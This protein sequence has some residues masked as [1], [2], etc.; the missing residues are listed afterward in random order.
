[1]KIFVALAC[2]L[3]GCLAQRPHPCESPPLLTG[4]FSV[5]AQN[6]DLFGLGKYL[7][8][9]I[10]ERIRVF[11]LVT[12]DNQTFTYDVLAN[13]REQVL[14]Q[15]NEKDKTCQK[16]PLKANFMPLGVPPGSSLVAQSVLG[17][18][19][20]PGKDSWSTPGQEIRR[21]M[22]TV[23][24]FG[25]VP[26][27]FVYQLKPYGWMHVSYFDNVIGITNPDQLNPPSFCSDANTMTHEEPVD[28]M[29]LFQPK[30]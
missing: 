28:F 4:G 21:F 27:T 1:M 9:A 3:A 13:Y 26:V 23:T 25:C 24:E 29:S 22:T 17:D 16:S 20:R 5:F 18:S 14:Y 2:L 7:Y 15:I 12:L 11:E 8:D 30:N 19:S 6:D 10:G